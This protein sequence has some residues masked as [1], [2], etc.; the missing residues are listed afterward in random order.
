[1]KSKERS[2]KYELRRRHIDRDQVEV[3]REAKKK[4]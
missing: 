2:V 1:V 3:V 4:E